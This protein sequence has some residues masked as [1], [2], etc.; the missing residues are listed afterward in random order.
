MISFLICAIA[1]FGDLLDCNGD[2]VV[3][4]NV[5]AYITL[6]LLYNI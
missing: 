2:D 5:S 4:Y 3:V 6:A 1:L